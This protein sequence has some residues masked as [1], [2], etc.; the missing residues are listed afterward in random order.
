[1]LLTGCAIYGLKRP[2][3]AVE[4]VILMAEEVDGRV[5]QLLQIAEQILCA[6]CASAV[7]QRVVSL[8]LIAAARGN[9][10]CGGNDR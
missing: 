10:Q 4:R 3:N 6:L 9:N 5:A 1:M 7:S 2:A 8:M